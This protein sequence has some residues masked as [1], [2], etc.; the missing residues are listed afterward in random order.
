[1]TAPQA[2]ATP[3]WFF[4]GQWLVS[5]LSQSVSLARGPDTPTRRSTF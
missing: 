4:C 5:M 3:F 2:R 1:M